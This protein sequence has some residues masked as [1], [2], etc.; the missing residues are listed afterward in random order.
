MRSITRPAAALAMALWLGAC[1]PM[2]DWREV[3]PDGSGMLAMFP[4]KPTQ[5]AR[6]LSLAGQ[7]VLLN[8]VAC[9]AGDATWALTFADLGDPTRLGPALDALRA[10]TLDNLDA[11]GARLQALPL[12]VP[13]ATPHPASGRVGF[14][15][16]RPDGQALQAQVA[17]FAKGTRAFQATVIGNSLPADGLEAFFDGLQA[18]E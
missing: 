11:S 4:C 3:R 7:P 10:A 8:L 2:L 6:R 1:S 16:T 18:L 14:N 17:V 13:G 12:A 5:H 9:S 15:G